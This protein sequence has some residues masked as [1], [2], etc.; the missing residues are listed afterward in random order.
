MREDIR[1]K[2][3]TGYTSRNINQRGLDGRYD[4]FSDPILQM[5]LNGFGIYTFCD[6][7]SGRPLYAKVVPLPYRCSTIGH[8]YL[9]MIL[10]RGCPYRHQLCLEA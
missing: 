4:I 7:L 10:T 2:N 3:S 5:G 1:I 9:D 6:E 8:V